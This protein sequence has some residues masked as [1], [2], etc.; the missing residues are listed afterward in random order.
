MVYNVYIEIK[1]VVKMFS[2]EEVKKYRLELIAECQQKA[3]DCEVIGLEEM[4]CYYD[5]KVEDYRKM[6]FNDLLSFMIYKKGC[7]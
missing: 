4:A 1:G 5:E 7:N 6:P 2:A 3:C